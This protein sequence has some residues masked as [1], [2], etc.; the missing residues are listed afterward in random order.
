MGIRR[1]VRRATTDRADYVRGCVLL[2]QELTGITARQA[3]TALRPT[4]PGWQLRTDD[5][6]RELSTWESCAKGAEVLT[7]V[8]AVLLGVTPTR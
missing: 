4:V 7:A 8:A 6:G 5:P 2:S 1:D 3:D